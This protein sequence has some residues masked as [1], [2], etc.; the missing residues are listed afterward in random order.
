MRTADRTLVIGALLKTVLAAKAAYGEG[1]F[2][3]LLTLRHNVRDT[4]LSD[5]PHIVLQVFNDT[6]HARAKET[7]VH[8]EHRLMMSL[9][10]HDTTASCRAVPDESTTILNKRS[11]GCH[12]CGLSRDGWNRNIG[13]LP[14]DGVD[15][16]IEL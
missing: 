6:H 16:R 5:N 15:E 13:Y 7:S 1:P 9:L 8:V 3:I 4:M 10:V 12:R 11:G 2:T 14:T